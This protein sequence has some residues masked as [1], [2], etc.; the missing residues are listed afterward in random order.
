MDRIDVLT[1]LAATL[2]LAVIMW[3]KPLRKLPFWLFT[4]LCLVFHLV[5]TP[6]YPALESA[7]GTAGPVA[8]WT[9]LCSVSIL[10]AALVASAHQGIKSFRGVHADRHSPYH[11]DI[12][13]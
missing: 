10:F 7:V 8:E 3:S 6:L 12:E 5:S 1:V 9:F 11:Q 13:V 4:L 2:A